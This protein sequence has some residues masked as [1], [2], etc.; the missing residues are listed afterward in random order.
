M[1]FKTGNLLKKKNHM[2]EAQDRG[3]FKILKN[4]SWFPYFKKARKKPMEPGRLT[5]ISQDAC[6]SL[7]HADTGKP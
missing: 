2:P 3:K 4:S 6:A 7:V 1:S 5:R